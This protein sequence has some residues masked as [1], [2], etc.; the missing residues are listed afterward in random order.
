VR[1]KFYV[2]VVPGIA[3]AADL[4]AATAGARESVKSTKS[5][6]SVHVVSEPDEAGAAAPFADRVDA[7]ASTLVDQF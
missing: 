6:G 4:A 5:G 1:G 7:V 2:V 3:K